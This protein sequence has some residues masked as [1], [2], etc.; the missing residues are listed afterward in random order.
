MYTTNLKMTRTIIF[1][2]VPLSILSCEQ[3]QD[4]SLLSQKKSNDTNVEFK[5]VVEDKEGFNIIDYLYFYNG[6]GVSIGDI[7]N[8]G[9]PDLYFTSNQSKNRLYL[10]KGG[11]EFEDIT[12]KANVG[13]DPDEWSTGANMADVNGDGYLDI[14]VCQVDYLSKEGHNLLYIND[15]NTMF[16]EKSEQYNLDFRGTSTQ[17]AFLD[18]DRDGDLDLYL[19]NHSIHSKDSFKKSSYRKVDAS[20]VGD[21]LYRN[22]DGFFED[23]T[24]EAGIYSSALG[25]GLGLA[26]SDI[27]K[28]GWPDIYVGN[29]FHEDDYL[30]INNGDGTFTEKLQEMVGHTSRSSM[31]NDISDFNNDGDPDILSLDMLP[32]SIARYRTSA[33]PDAEKISRVKKRF[34]Y[35]PQYSRNT[36]Q[37]NRGFGNDGYPIFSEIGLYSGIYAT[38]WSWAGLFV[39]LDNDSWKDIFITNGILR[40]PNDLDYANY[41]S[42]R[43]TQKIL[44]NASMER[45][46]EVLDNM[47]SAKSRNYIFENNRDLTFSDKSSDWSAMD[48][49]LSNGAAYG[50]FDNDGD[51][52]IAVNNLN[53]NASIYKNNAS[54]LRDNNYLAVRLSSSSDNST[55]IG[56]KVIVYSDGKTLYREQTPTRGFQSSVSHAPHFGLGTSKQVDSLLVIWPDGQFQRLQ[57]VNTNQEIVLNKSNADDLYSYGNDKRKG[58]LFTEVTSS[59][60]IEFTHREND[61]VDFKRQ[62]LIPHKLSTQGPTLAV[63]DVNG[64][65]LDD[66]YVGGAHHQAGKLFIRQPDGDFQATGQQTFRQDKRKE[67]VDATFFDADGDGDQDLYVVSGGGEYNVG[68]KPLQDRLYLNDGEGNFTRSTGALP[69]TRSDGASVSATDYD[70]DGDVDLFVGSRSIPGSYGKSPKSYLLENNGAGTFSDV[71]TEKAPELRRLGMITDAT[72]ADV[73]GEKKKELVIV[74]EW[75][76]ATVFRNLNDRLKNITDEVDLDKTNGFWKTVYADDFD[77]DNDSDLVAGNLGTNSIFRV[78]DKKPL[79]LFI[80]DFNGNGTTDPII[81]EH[82]KDNLYTWARRDELLDQIPGLKERIPTYDAY[83]DMTID[84]IFS[85]RKMRNSVRRK[86]NTL[87]SMYFENEEGKFNAHSLPEKSQ[88]SPIQSMISYRF[89]NGGSRDILTGGNF[90]GS[91]N[92]QGRYDAGYGL[93]LSSDGR[94][95]FKT[96]PVERSGFVIRGEVRDIRMVKGNNLDPIIIVA[97]NDDSLQFY[98]SAY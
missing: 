27:N 79:E 30:Y 62:P 49:G 51:I 95:S 69:E 43:R 82:R 63:A 90:F 26:V 25:Y 91:D 89:S 4:R 6:G 21:K 10:N 53:G 83:S 67:D 40:R 16:T 20:K 57:Q 88:L 41:V 34:G 45:Q 35:S 92:K 71:T 47:P 59:F 86:V 22:N 98:K 9:L 66:F 52:D 54:T 17:A 11:F 3:G 74:G 73:Y 31:G 81:A 64:D 33:G 29:D 60:N 61:F 96:V 28:D 94:G 93:L 7:D 19:M 2:F 84:D 78:S 39:D 36:L 44:S 50:D 8:D 24:I 72:W 80:N 58:S 56:S 97:R 76:P 5:N 12:S 18:Y 75:M 55:G 32:E 1:L 23:V 87:K 85:E 13:G 14:Y 48:K 77:N 68:E 65:G 37:L 70:G 38:D 46:L 42:R 15:G